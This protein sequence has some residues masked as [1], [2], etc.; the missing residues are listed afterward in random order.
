MVRRLADVP[1]LAVRTSD[2]DYDLPKSAIAQ[3]PAEPRDDARMMVVGFDGEATHRR[4][5]GLPELLRAGDLIVVNDT[6]VRRARI[7]LHKRT[8]GAAEVLVLAHIEGDTWEALVRPARR[9]AP[10][11]LL[12]Q[13][14]G[15]G[16]GPAAVEV[17]GPLTTDETASGLHGV[18]L[19]GC[20]TESDGAA[21][22]ERLGSVPLPPYV[23][24]PDVDPD[25][26]QT[27]FARA[28]RSVAAPTAGLHLT[29]N[30]LQ[31][32]RDQGVGVVEVSLDVGLGTF[33]PL[34]EPQL[35]DNV[36]HEERY[37]VSPATWAACLATRD[38][39]GRV[40]AVGTTV[41]RAL[42]TAASTGELAGMS[43]L[44]IK[45]GFHFSL[46]DALLTN[47]HMPKSSLLVLLEAFMGSRWR[48]TYRTA[49]ED[50]YRFLSLGD[51]MF[52]ERSTGETLGPAP[53]GADGLATSAGRIE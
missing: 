52:V 46:V 4:V 31:R 25:R 5:A 6:R 50:G 19:V 24:N 14:D 33:R 7:H 20:P 37:D 48:D 51:C 42:E 10:G 41:V 1:L 2:F 29:E 49:L 36:M 47:Y 27:V 22:I 12:Y 39:G 38:S 13:R 21:M 45:P 17:L 18:R 28:P 23:V 44:F 3:T 35:E 8:G 40:V 9:L 53:D 16:L 30:L 34:V 32:C 11:T 15:D 43:R 26:Y